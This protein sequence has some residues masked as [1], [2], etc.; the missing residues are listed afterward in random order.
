MI[1]ARRG[2]GCNEGWPGR[3]VR[4]SE[5]VW[6]CWDHGFALDRVVY[7]PESHFRAVWCTFMALPGTCEARSVPATVSPNRPVLRPWERPVDSK[8]PS[9]LLAPVHVNSAPL[10]THWNHHGRLSKYIYVWPV[11]GSTLSERVSTSFFSTTK[12]LSRRS[13]FIPK[14]VQPL[15][16]IGRGLKKW[17]IFLAWVGNGG[18]PWAG[19]PLVSRRWIFWEPHVIGSNAVKISFGSF[20]S[21]HLWDA[22]ASPAYISWLLINSRRESCSS[23]LEVFC[24]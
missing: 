20:G 4:A 5:A 24:T 8:L 15:Q 10:S 14:R 13:T 12:S 17:P 23:R 21:L 2:P 18:G 6:R 16:A 9:I 11:Q 3:L 22:P 19:A 1:L 7:D